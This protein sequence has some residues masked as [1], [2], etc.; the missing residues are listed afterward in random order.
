MAYLELH[1]VATHA[2]FV[3]RVK[4]AMLKYA[5]DTAGE[6]NSSL[7]D[8]VLAKRQSLAMQVFADA[9][10]QAKKFAFHAATYGEG[11]VAVDESGAL[12][13]TGSDLDAAIDGIMDDLWND[14]AGVTYTELNTV[15]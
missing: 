11:V 8:V 15:V 6:N 9:D 2:E 3:K 13:F 7:S 5:A 4:M 1:K 10:G 14:R 12:T